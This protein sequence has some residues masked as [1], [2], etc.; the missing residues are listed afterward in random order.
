MIPGVDHGVGIV[1]VY[2][3]CARECVNV[4]SASVAVSNAKRCSQHGVF[5]GPFRADSTLIPVMHPRLEESGFYV[6]I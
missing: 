3:S 2:E 6:Y 4:F 5:I 1:I